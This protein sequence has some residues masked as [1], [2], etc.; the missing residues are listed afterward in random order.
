VPN[1]SG[2]VERIPVA[3]ARDVSKVVAALKCNARK[4]AKTTK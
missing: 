2:K 4:S 1:G 3:N